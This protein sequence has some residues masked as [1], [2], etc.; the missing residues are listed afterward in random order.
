MHPLRLEYSEPIGRIRGLR[1]VKD[2]DGRW[3]LPESIHEVAE[4][5]RAN[6]GIFRGQKLAGEG[7]I[8]ARIRRPVSHHKEEDLRPTGE[9]QATDVTR[10][11]LLAVVRCDR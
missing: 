3:H 2:G 6:G 8:I 5:G 4:L 1:D 10:E 7:A 9:V 11:A